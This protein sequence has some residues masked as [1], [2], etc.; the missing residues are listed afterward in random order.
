MNNKCEIYPAN[1]TVIQ[2][3]QQTIQCCLCIVKQQASNSI[4]T[5]HQICS[6]QNHKLFPLKENLLNYLK[7]KIAWVINF[8]LSQAD[9]AVE[10]C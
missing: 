10:K 7:K 2:Y 6:D 1:L 5:N 8:P 9:L 4:A 3:F